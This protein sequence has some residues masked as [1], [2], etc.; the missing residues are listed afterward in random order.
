MNRTI[1]IVPSLFLAL[2]GCKD[3]G[4]SIPAGPAATQESA[5]PLTPGPSET[6]ATECDPAKTT[7]DPVIWTIGLKDLGGL[8]GSDRE[9]KRRVKQGGKDE[10]DPP[11]MTNGKLY[12]TNLDLAANAA[13]LADGQ[14]VEIRI[15][16]EPGTNGKRELG[17]VRISAQPEPGQENSSAAAVTA[18]A[19]NGTN[20]CRFKL[21]ETDSDG[22][23]VVRIGSYLA[24]GAESSINVGL[25]VYSSK[26]G[27]FTPIYIDPNVRNEG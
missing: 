18:P 24:K 6:I 10:P 8:S 4:R 27:L 14:Y 16:V 23:E 22:N 26:S 9:I 21:I 5:G 20:F 7:G 11:K 1:I 2:A 17:F 25:L 12:P 13:A 3:G 19:G 15:V